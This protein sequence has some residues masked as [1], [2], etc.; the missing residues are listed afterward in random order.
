MDEIEFRQE[1][2]NAIHFR[3]MDLIRTPKG[4][5]VRGFITSP[6]MTC[7]DTHYHNGRTVPCTH[8]TCD[9]CDAGRRMQEHVY[10][11]VWNKENRHH[12]LFECTDFAALPFIK[13]QREKESIRGLYFVATR[14][15]TKANARVAIRIT[16]LPDPDIALPAAVNVE[17]VLRAIWKKPT[18]EAERH[19]SV[20][21]D[22]ERW[23]HLTGTDNGTKS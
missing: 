13:A 1:P 14:P 4:G 18:Y 6:K 23:N 11:T 3:G 5:S 21:Y 20:T 7:V 17:Q 16:A 8:P 9:A 19:E 12:F 22:K 10:V 2:K 15:D